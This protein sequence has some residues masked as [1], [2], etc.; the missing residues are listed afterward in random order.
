MTKIASIYITT[1][2]CQYLKTQLE[3][4]KKKLTKDIQG[5]WFRNSGRI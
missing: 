2:G 3:R 5:I 4:T 1:S